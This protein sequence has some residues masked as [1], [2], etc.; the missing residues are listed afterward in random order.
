MASLIR[1]IVDLHRRQLFGVI[2]VRGV[3]RMRKLYSDARGELESKLRRLTRTGRGDTFQAQHLRM[4]LT[5]V[6]D[7]V[8]TFQKDL[9]HHMDTT[10]RMAGNLAPRHLVSMVGKMEAK[11]GEMTPVVQAAQAAVVRG[12]YPDVARTL[13]DKYRESAEFYG[14]ETMRAIRTGLAHSIVQEET[15]DEAVGRVV[16]SDGLFDAQR[17]RA[18]RIVRTEM[19]YSYHA[20]NQRGLEQLAPAVPKMMKRLVTTHDDRTGEDSIELDGQTV[21]VD[22]PFV[23]VVKDARGAPTGKVV[24]YMAPPNRPNDRE[25]VIPW[26]AGWA[27][28]SQVTDLGGVRPSVPADLG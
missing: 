1:E 19:S 20:T 11:F 21:P 7:T 24:R 27:D 3:G 12:A 10:G 2:E 26:V 6:A 14:P 18:E 4:V 17:W 15:V 23:W 28:P 16:E 5:Q 9:V 8:A 22:Q 25:T 13:L